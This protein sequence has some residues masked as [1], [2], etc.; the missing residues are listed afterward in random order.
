[1]KVHLV[2]KH[3]QMFKKDDKE[4]NL[5]VS[6]SIQCSHGV[7]KKIYL[8]CYYNIISDFDFSVNA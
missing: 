8:T 7:R 5:S 1:M 3:Y 4:I 6:G 2:T